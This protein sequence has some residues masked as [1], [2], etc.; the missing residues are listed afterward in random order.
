MEVAL[1]YRD[2]LIIALLAA[3]PLRKRT[4]AALTTNQHLVKIGDYWL[5]D[6]PAADTKTRR[7]LEFPISDAL[8]ERIDL[9]LARFA[10][11]SRVR[12]LT[13]DSGHR[14]AANRWVADQFTMQCV[15]GPRKH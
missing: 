15:V 6:I 5:L 13:T 10:A 4:V 8:S 1:T 7:P 3:V 9:Y 11:R 12:T 2:G 14:R